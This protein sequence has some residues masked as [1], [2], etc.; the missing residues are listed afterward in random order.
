MHQTTT[1]PQITADYLAHTRQKRV[2]NMI[3]LV[4]FVALL[5]GGFSTANARNAGG[6][7]NGLPN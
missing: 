6:F 3:L 2:M 5:I 1:A 7:W 4:V